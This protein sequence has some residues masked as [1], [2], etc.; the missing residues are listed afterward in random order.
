M[1]AINVAEELSVL[2]QDV[3]KAIAFVRNKNPTLAVC[4][5]AKWMERS[6]GS[7]ERIG[8]CKAEFP[9][10]VDHHYSTGVT[11]R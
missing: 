10:L 1:T 6:F 8:V 2:V 4:G 7:M 3:D 9:G 5:C 11:V